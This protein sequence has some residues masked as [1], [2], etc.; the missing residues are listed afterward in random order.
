MRTAAILCVS[1]F[2]G[3]AFAQDPGTINVPGNTVVY[4][5]A[6]NSTSAQ[7]YS[8]A[9]IDASVFYYPA[10]SD[11]IC[12]VINKI[13]RKQYTGVG[14]PTAGAVVDARG[15]LEGNNSTVCNINPFDGITGSFNTTILL[16]ATTIRT[17]CPWILPSN[18]H[19]DQGRLEQTLQLHG[20]NEFTG[21][22]VQLRGGNVYS[23]CALDQS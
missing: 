12:Q 21:L 16:P 8:A 5:S 11:T 15:I 2:L 17:Q 23:R 6:S 13:L 9:Y 22:S 20:Q 14:Y 18:T 1:L 7:S 10:E 3:M 4:N 19:I